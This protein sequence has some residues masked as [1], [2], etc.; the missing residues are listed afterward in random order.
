MLTTWDL[1]CSNS[2]CPDCRR[3]PSRHNFDSLLRDGVRPRGIPVQGPDFSALVFLPFRS[4]FPLRSCHCHHTLRA[5]F[6]AVAAFEFHFDT[7]SCLH[8]RNLCYHSLCGPF[9]VRAGSLSRCFCGS[10]EPRTG[11]NFLF[12]QS[13]QFRV[14][15]TGKKVEVGKTKR[16]RFNLKEALLYL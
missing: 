10:F 15:K 1:R 7:A 13:G 3:R 12:R 11:G 14:C 5:A 8:P 4:C 2:L 6:A 9:L 16:V